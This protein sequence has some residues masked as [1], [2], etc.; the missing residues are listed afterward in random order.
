M[1]SFI[2][3]LSLLKTFYSLNKI[4]RLIE[5][6]L[7]LK[8]L[9]NNQFM[10]YYQLIVNPYNYKVMTCESLLRFNDG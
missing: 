5:Q 1:V 2:L 8:Q 3:V 4:V 7:F 9:K 10:L 6:K